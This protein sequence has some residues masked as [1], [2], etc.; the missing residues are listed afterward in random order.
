MLDDLK[1][2]CNSAHNLLDILCAFSILIHH[3][4]INVFPFL[5]FQSTDERT[6]LESQLRTTTLENIELT[7]EM[8][9]LEVEMTSVRSRLLT[10]LNE[11]D[12]CKEKQAED[13]NKMN[14]LRQKFAN[15]EK[16]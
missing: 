2:F 5:C 9:R 13:N 15:M 14:L 12:I 10:T 11:L 16:Q 4:V 7:S 8:Q 3:T 6:Q 1:G